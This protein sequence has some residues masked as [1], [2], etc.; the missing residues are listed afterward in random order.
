MDR[1]LFTIAQKGEDGAPVSLARDEAVEETTRFEDRRNSMGKSR[2]L[3][4]SMKGIGQ[5]NKIDRLRHELGNVISVTSDEIAVRN[6]ALS[7][8]NT[9]DFEQFWVEV[10]CKNV[11]RYLCNLQRKPAIAGAQ[12]DHLHA[13]R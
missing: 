10:N 7:E 11:V 5:K 2:W 9:C 6:T 13:R 3:W 1:Y 4:N 8:P 12:I